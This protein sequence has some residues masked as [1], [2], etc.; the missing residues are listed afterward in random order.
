MPCRTVLT[1]LTF[2][3]S[4]GSATSVQQFTG[5]ERDSESGLDYFGARYY[6]SALGRWTSPDKLNLTSARLLSPTNTLNKYAYAANNPLKFIDPDGRDV[7]IFYRPPTS[8]PVDF[9]HVLIGALN[10]STGKAGFLDY[11]PRGGGNGPGQFNL[12]T[13]QERAAT[14]DQFLTLTVQTSPEEAQQVLDLITKLTGSNPPDYAALSN[15]CTTVCQDVLHD[16]GLDF[17]DVFPKDYWADV[18]RNF[19]PAVWDN[20]FKAFFVPT[21]PGVEYGNP[22]NVGTD[23]A[24]FLF[25]VYLNQQLNKPVTACVDAHDDKGN[26]TGQTCSQ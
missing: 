7:T 22:R 19:S 10:Q 12:G 1:N 5:K 6:G 2:G 20:P 14:R 4:V 9:G 3:A 16:L 17:G 15:N 18:Y 25:Q 23:F 13:M 24:T 21:K 8:S 11:Y 26:S